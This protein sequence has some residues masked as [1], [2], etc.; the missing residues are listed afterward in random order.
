MLDLLSAGPPLHQLTD[1]AERSGLSLPTVH[2]LLRSLVAAG[3]VR[4]DPRSLRY[5]LG[6]ELVRLA[7]HYLEH[8]PV[9]AAVR[10]ELAPLSDRLGATAAVA[11]LAGT[12]VVYVECRNHYRVATDSPLARRR[13]ALDTAAGRVL[14]A[15]ADPQAWDAACAARPD[16]DVLE[17]AR[18]TWRSASHVLRDPAGDADRAEVAVAVHD[19]EGVVAALSSVLHADELSPQ[20]LRGE[21]VPQLLAAAARATERLR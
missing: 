17:D 19:G 20:R 18:A 13:A 2:R 14:L 4:Q 9:V 6:P 15:T 12:D 21:I 11:I 7:E 3:L 5:G 10:G 8:L 16:R 1:L